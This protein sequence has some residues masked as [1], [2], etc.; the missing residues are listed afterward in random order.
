VTLTQANQRNRQGAAMRI[1]VGA[2]L[3]LVGM[4]VVLSGAVILISQ[5]TAGTNRVSLFVGFGCV[6]LVT[7]LVNVLE[8]LAYA[9]WALFAAVASIATELIMSNLVLTHAPVP[10]TA[11]IA[12]TLVGILVA[13]PPLL[14]LL[15]RPGRVLA[16][17]L[18]IQ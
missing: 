1:F 7:L 3:R 4:T 10:G 11:L 5:W 14:R 18:W 17:S 16:T 12:G 2:L 13:L 6:A 8:S 15:V 9:R